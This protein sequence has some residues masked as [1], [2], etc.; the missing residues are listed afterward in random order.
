MHLHVIWNDLDARLQLHLLF[1]I[2]P[3]MH[4]HVGWRKQYSCNWVDKQNT[5]CTYEQS[6]K[7]FMLYMQHSHTH[8]H[9]DT[10]THTRTHTHTHTHTWTKHDQSYCLYST[11]LGHPTPSTWVLICLL[12]LHVFDFAYSANIMKVKCS[13]CAYWQIDSHSR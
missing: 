8:T 1:L 9:K 13:H 10:H 5:W 4:A 6:N 11:H 7:T 3:G 12:L 2:V